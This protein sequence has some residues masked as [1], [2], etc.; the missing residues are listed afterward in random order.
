MPASR[1]GHAGCP[2]RII[3]C[4]SL[5]VFWRSF[6]VPNRQSW[7]ERL[8]CSSSRRVN[9]G[10]IF[11][12]W[13]GF[14]MNQSKPARRLLAIP[15]VWEYCLLVS[16]VHLCWKKLYSE[17]CFPPFLA[18]IPFFWGSCS[19]YC[20]FP[21]YICRRHQQFSFYIYL[22][23]VYLQHCVYSP[24]VWFIAI[25]CMLWSTWWLLF[26]CCN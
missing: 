11:W 23:A 12:R 8:S 14:N 17:N 16:W 26:Y 4:N 21:H 18:R 20:Y 9:F 6:S 10:L 15:S 24:V 5:T 1:A 25:W 19:V 3:V 7:K 2:G 22:L 13:S